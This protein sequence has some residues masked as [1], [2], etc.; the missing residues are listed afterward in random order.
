MVASRH[1]CQPSAHPSTNHSPPRASSL[2][3]T[4]FAVLCIAVVDCRCREV[5]LPASPSAALPLPP[6]RA[7]SVPAC[8]PNGSPPLS[9]GKHAQQAASKQASKHLRGLFPSC[10][11]RLSISSLPHSHRV[12]CYGPPLLAQHLW[13]LP[14][15]A[16]ST[17]TCSYSNS[18][19]GP[20]SHSS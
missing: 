8:L 13:L 1:S 14:A 4:H 6:L 2:P 19:R 18:R 5:V 10:H 9:I 17:E 11:G 3:A 20:R 16:S 12:D 7:L 15:P